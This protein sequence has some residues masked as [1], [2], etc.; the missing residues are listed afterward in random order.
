MKKEKRKKEIISLTRIQPLPFT[1]VLTHLTQ[2]SHELL[3]S[4]SVRS[5]SI[6]IFD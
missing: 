4:R 3:L 6:N 2:R 5:F 1:I